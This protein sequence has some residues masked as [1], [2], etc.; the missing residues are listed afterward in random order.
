MQRLRF[1]F[2]QLTAIQ[3]QQHQQTLLGC[4]QRTEQ[5]MDDH[6]QVQ[7]EMIN[8]FLSLNNTKDNNLL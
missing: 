3:F 8:I 6:L 5:P 2:V 1:R 4:L 7:I